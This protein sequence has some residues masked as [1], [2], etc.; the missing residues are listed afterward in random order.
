MFVLF[1]M[2]QEGP[3][4]IHGKSHKLLD[5]CIVTFL[6]DP[7]GVEKP[8]SKGQEGEPSGMH[9]GTNF[10]CYKFWVYQELRFMSENI[11]K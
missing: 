7:T 8:D 4:S 1:I 10:V 11:R 5:V 9:Q 3:Y 2:N 6:V